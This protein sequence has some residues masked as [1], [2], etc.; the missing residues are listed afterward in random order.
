MQLHTDMRQILLARGYLHTRQQA[1]VQA[2]N[3]LFAKLSDLQLH[4]MLEGGNL[5][6]HIRHHGFIPWDGRMRFSLARDEYDIL[7]DYAVEHFPTFPLDTPIK[8]YNDLDERTAIQLKLIADHPNQW[9]VM[10]GADHLHIFKGKN[11]LEIIDL[12]FHSMDRLSDTIAFDD[13]QSYIHQQRAMEQTCTTLADLLSYRR[14]A[15]QD[16]P[17]YQTDGVLCYP[18]LDND[19]SDVAI[20]KGFAKSEW[21]LPWVKADFESGSFF[22]CA[23][24]EK[25]LAYYY[26]DYMRFPRDAGSC[27]W[28]EAREEAVENACPSVEFYL[29]DAFEVL[30]FEPIYHALRA[31]G[32]CTV[33]V[34]EPPWRN[35]VGDWFDYENAVKLLEEHSLQYKTHANLDCDAAVTTQAAYQLRRYH[36]KK[37]E[38][39]YGIALKKSDFY[40]LPLT[41]KD[42]DLVLVH[43]KFHQA[44]MKKLASDLPT[45]IMGYPK[46]DNFWKSPLTCKTARHSLNIKTD[47]P[48]IVYLPTWDDDSSISVFADRLTAL[49]KDYYIVSRPHH[50]TCHLPEK[51]ED[52]K[53]LVVASNIVLPA[54]ASFEEA[55]CCADILISDAKSGA[56]LESIFINPYAAPVAICVNQDYGTAFYHELGISANVVSRPEE[57]NAAFLASLKPKDTALIDYYFDEHTGGCAAKAANAIVALIN[58][59]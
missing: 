56:M 27:A 11:Q 16:Y 58:Q 3:S 35:V 48:V 37:V 52:Y 42:F 22:T 14:K 30:H 26:G 9:I 12:E 6:G 40:T 28:I 45:A 47:K 43:G 50:C 34:A 44:L 7:L 20:N 49:Q 53:K 32:V 54:H 39:H 19:M 46:Y 38:L 59:A 13:W 33:F 4:P 31:I 29:V 1:L 21:L 41:Y 25:W 57:L 5:L 18:G 36:G 15:H 10:P 23:M 51:A 8:T 17:H 2:A 24:P 55:V